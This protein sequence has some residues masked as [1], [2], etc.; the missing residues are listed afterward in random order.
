[1]KRKAIFSIIIIIPVF[2]VAIFFCT[3]EDVEI[4]E[5]SYRYKGAATW[6]DIFESTI[7]KTNHT[8]EV[9]NITL[10][11][12]AIFDFDELTENNI[13]YESSDIQSYTGIELEGYFFSLGY[14]FRNMDDLLLFVPFTDTAY[15][16]NSIA[17][18]SYHVYAPRN[19]FQG[20]LLIQN[21]GILEMNLNHTSGIN[22]QLSGELYDLGDGNLTFSASGNQ[23]VISGVAVALS[24]E[25][26]VIDLGVGE[27]IIFA[28]KNSSEEPHKTGDYT[29]IGLEFNVYALDYITKFISG[30]LTVHSDN[31][32]ILAIGEDIV[33]DS[34]LTNVSGSLYSCNHNAQEILFQFISE[35]LVCITALP[36]EASDLYFFAVGVYE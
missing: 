36:A 24:G 17:A 33:I 35:K 31:S 30:D 34:M 3:S 15:D 11:E 18:N 9:E 10:G 25:M 2:C 6:G 22:E 26:I 1:M 32:F 19:L 7:N 14:D 12:E 21:N 5:D 8:L 16:M 23:T 27:G 29:L 13:I 20:E 28:L 4:D